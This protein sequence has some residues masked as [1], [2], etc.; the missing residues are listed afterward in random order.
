MRDVNH[1]NAVLTIREREIM[2]LV[3]QGKTYLEISKLLSLSTETIKTHVQKV[4][5]KLEAINRTHA[6][7]I[8]V[9]H[10]LVLLPPSPLRGIPKT[11]CSGVLKCRCNR[12]KP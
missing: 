2:T 11:I 4:C 7:A 6:V 1:S 8:A 5:R 9:N 12:E 10:K 3:A